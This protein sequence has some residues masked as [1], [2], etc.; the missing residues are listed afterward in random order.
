M[1]L[2]S[3]IRNNPRHPRT[4][5]VTDTWG[6]I[7]VDVKITELS[8]FFPRMVF[9]YIHMICRRNSSLQM[10]QLS[11]LFSCLGRT[12]PPDQ[13]VN[14]PFFMKTLPSRLV[15]KFDPW[16]QQKGGQDVPP[17]WCGQSFHSLA[18]MYGPESPRPGRSNQKPF[19]LVPGPARDEMISITP[20]AAAGG[21]GLSEDNGSSFFLPAKFGWTDKQTVRILQDLNLLC[22]FL[23]PTCKNH[24]CKSPQIKVVLL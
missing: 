2:L 12:F 15:W 22:Y 24:Q 9:C 13:H 8:L 7:V 11:P 17:P 6:I 20:A 18:A 21:A 4:L 16:Y 1:T 3:S 5:S 10:S 14:T 23:L 19:L